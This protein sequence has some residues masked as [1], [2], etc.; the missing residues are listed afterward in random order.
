[1]MAVVG[2]LPGD[3]SVYATLSRPSRAEKLALDAVRCRLD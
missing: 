1:M 2:P 3:M